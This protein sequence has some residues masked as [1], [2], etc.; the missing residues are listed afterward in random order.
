MSSDIQYI[1][2]SFTKHVYR[3]YIG[4][5]TTNPLLSRV[6]NGMH[7]SDYAAGFRNHNY[8]CNVTFQGSDSSSSYFTSLI[9]WRH[10][11]YG[12]IEG[13]MVWR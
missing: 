8:G 2:M 9:I 6:Q 10:V 5:V 4:I 11:L 1:D 3:G 13:I 12:K 7:R